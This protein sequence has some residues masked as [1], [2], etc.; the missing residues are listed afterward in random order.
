MSIDLKKI[1]FDHILVNFV[2]AGMM[3]I[4]LLGHCAKTP[5]FR[6]TLW[7]I[8]LKMAQIIAWLFGFHSDMAVFCK[9]FCFVSIGI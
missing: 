5:Q 4:A 3:L 7:I 2:H 9:M 6:G 1:K 8:E